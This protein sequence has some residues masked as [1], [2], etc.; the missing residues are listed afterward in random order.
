MLSSSEKEYNM[1]PKCDISLLQESERS[2]CQEFR[3]GAAQI[4]NV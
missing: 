1:E 4:R 3:L 2:R